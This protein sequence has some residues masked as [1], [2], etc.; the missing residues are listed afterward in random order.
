MFFFHVNVL[1]V[2]FEVFNMFHRCLVMGGGS[3][4]PCRASIITEELNKN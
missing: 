4:K 1:F 2:P 3:S